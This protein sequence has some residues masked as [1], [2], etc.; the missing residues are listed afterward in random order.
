MEQSQL[1]FDGIEVKPIKDFARQAYL[2]YSMYVILDRALPSVADGLKPVQRRII[3]AMSELGLS[4]IS[5]HKKSARTVGDVLGKYH[6]HGDSACYEAMVLMAQDFSYRYP[7]VDGQGNWGSIDDPKSFAAMR[8]TEARL[9]PYAA[10]LLSELKQGTVKWGDNFD[11][12][13]KEPL[14]LPAQVPNILLNGGMGIAVGMATDIPPHNLTEVLDGALKLLKHPNTTDESLF[15]LIPAPDFP[16]GAEIITPEVERLKAYQTG[17]GSIK[18]RANYE[19]EDDEIVIQNLP[20]QVSISKVTEQIALQIQSKKLPWLTNVRDESDHENPVRLVLSMRSNR[21]NVQRLMSHLFATTE[22]EKN[23]RLNFNMIALDGKPKVMSLKEVLI[24][25]LAFR[26]HTVTCRLESRLDKVLD[27]LHILDGLLIAYLNLDEVIA[28]IRTEDE[29]KLKLMERFKLT[30]RQADSILDTKLR[31]LAKLEE[32]KLKAEKDNLLEEKDYLEGCLNSDDKMTSLISD[33]LKQ[34]KKQYKD[35]RRSNIS[36]REESKALDESELLPTENV[37]I[38]LSKQGWI[39]SAK[40][41]DIKPEDM[42]YRSGDS[43]LVSA[44]G[45]SNEQVILVDKTGRVYS[46]KASDLPSARGQGEPITGFFNIDTHI[47]VNNISISASNGFMLLASKAG[48]GFITEVGAMLTKNKSGKQVLTV[49]D[50]L[51]VVEPV[52]IKEITDDLLVVCITNQGRVLSYPLKELPVLNKGKGNKLINMPSASVTGESL[53]WVCIVGEGDLLKLQVKKRFKL[54][55]YKD[56]LEYQSRRAAR[57]KRLPKGF[58]NIT[59]VFYEKNT[60]K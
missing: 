26:R 47:N 21:V 14:V 52:S 24:E 32:F 34:I 6:P 55:S 20:H 50:N 5:K 27:R 45:R 13:L 30:E 1:V 37:T 23:V 8:Y 46:M 16:G 35:P 44:K 36:F 60:Q 19:I 17:N 40:G 49:P 54:L 10:L 48:Y 31:H 28:I 38:V 39:R 29:P 2:N 3:Y 42:N 11:G 7:L 53:A 41:H 18:L 33:E 59:A 22:L 57:G 56:I 12:T 4:A 15:K 51:G 58:Q 43:Y 9:S 25:W